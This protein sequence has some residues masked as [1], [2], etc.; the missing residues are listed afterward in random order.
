M[1]CAPAIFFS[2]I[3]PLRSAIP[4][5]T[6][7]H[8]E[9]SIWRDTVLVEPGQFAQ[10]LARVHQR[11][12]CDCVR[13]ASSLWRDVALVELHLTPFVR[14]PLILLLTKKN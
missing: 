7:R 14:S 4:S 1:T 12:R 10:L 11:E 6:T 13:H 5:A 8:S 9:R 3:A 2:G